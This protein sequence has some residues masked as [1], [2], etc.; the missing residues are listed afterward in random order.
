MMILKTTGLLHSMVSTTRSTL[1]SFTT[2]RQPTKQWDGQNFARLS[3]ADKFTSVS[4]T[5]CMDEN[6]ATQ[7]VMEE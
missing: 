3:F 4:R 7:F 2:K 6:L 5:V 1:T